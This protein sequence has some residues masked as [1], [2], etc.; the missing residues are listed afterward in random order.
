MSRLRQMME[1]GRPCPS[2]NK[3]LYRKLDHQD[4]YKDELLI[5]QQA[6]ANLE[7]QL[8]EAL[9]KQEETSLNALK[10]A[11]RN[12]ELERELKEIDHLATLNVEADRHL[13]EKKQSKRV[14]KI[15]VFIYFLF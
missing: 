1:G 11:Q 6:K 9:G 2:T 3:D 14:S 5:A 15:Q 4:L 10:L 7:R 13:R 12:E 8:K